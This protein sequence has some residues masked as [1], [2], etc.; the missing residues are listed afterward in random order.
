M[1]TIRVVDVLHGPFSKAL[2]KKMTTVKPLD[3]YRR[4]QSAQHAVLEE[5]RRRLIAGALKPGDQVTQELLASELQTSVVPVREAL[6]TLETEGQIVHIPRRGFFVAELS[7]DELIEL[8]EIRSALETMAVD[9]SLPLLDGSDTAHMIELLEQMEFSEKDGDILRLVQLDRAFHFLVF[10]KAGPSQLTRLL[11]TTWD[12]S[13][14]Y[15]AAFFRSAEGLRRNRHEH[16]QIIEA[17]K[18][19]QRDR[20]VELLD[21]HRLSPVTQVAAISARH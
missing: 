6:K 11:R 4:P 5:L 16:H 3:A 18:L 1:Q 8:C 14:P 17:V 20:L 10:D 13:D 7:Q 2:R 9:R 15:R 19:K 21:A 12:Q